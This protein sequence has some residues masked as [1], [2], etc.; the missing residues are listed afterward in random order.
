V[1][2]VYSNF[3]HDIP[4]FSVISFV[5]GKIQSQFLLNVLTV[6]KQV[7]I[8][9]LFRFNLTP[10]IDA[11]GYVQRATIEFAKARVVVFGEAALF[12]VQV[13]KKDNGEKGL[14]GMNTS[15]AQSNKQFLLNKLYWMVKI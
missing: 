1:V 5:R 9:L 15:D 13:V 14:T 11:T 8:G 4:P 6:C 3:K 10:Q 12:S 2:V 7:S